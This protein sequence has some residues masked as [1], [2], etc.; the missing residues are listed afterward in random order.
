MKSDGFPETFKKH[1]GAHQ[2][3]DH[4]ASDSEGIQS[5]PNL[6]EEGEVYPWLC[7]LME[8]SRVSFPVVVKPVG[9]A[10]SFSVTKAEDMAQ[11]AAAIWEFNATLPTYL[12]NS[13]LSSDSTAATGVFVSSP[14]FCDP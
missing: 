4:V 11:L 7:G 8:A 10:G 3:F 13:G 1:E 9:C 6:T 2:P 5:L 12:A 14:L